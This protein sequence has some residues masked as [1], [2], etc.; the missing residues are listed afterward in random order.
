MSP[1][2]KHFARDNA[3]AETENFS[4]VFPISN[5][6]SKK[7]GWER[8]YLASGKWPRSF[9]ELRRKTRNFCLSRWSE[10]IYIK[11]HNFRTLHVENLIEFFPQFSKMFT[12]KSF[13]W[14]RRARDGSNKSDSGTS[15]L[16]SACDWIRMDSQI[17]AKSMSSRFVQ[18]GHVILHPRQYAPRKWILI[19]STITHRL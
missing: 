9:R 18:R 15:R 5:L 2:C 16:G 10:N 19:Y 4:R 6:D 14:K 13:E 7:R 8:I 1:T 17:R 3:A 11:K 12:A